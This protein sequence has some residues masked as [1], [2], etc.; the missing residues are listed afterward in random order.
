MRI[1]AVEE[2][3]SVPG[4][5]PELFGPGIGLPEVWAREWR[6]RLGDIGELR[7]ADMDAH[8]VDVQVLSLTAGVER[9]TNPAE[10]VDAARRANDHLA[11]AVAAHPDRFAGFCV[12][13]LQDPAAA[14]GELRRCVLELGMVGALQNDHV[15]GR[16]LDDIRFDEVWAELAQ[17]AVPL[18]LHPTYF[19]AERLALYADV[20]A[21]F[22]PTWGWTAATGGHALRLVYNGVFDRHPGAQLLLGHMGE[23]LPFQSA[24]LDSRAEQVPDQLRPPMAPSEYLRRNVH[25][26]TS[27]VASPAALRAAIDL[28]GV[29]RVLFAVDYPYERTAEAVELLAAPGISDAERAAVAHGNADRLLRLRPAG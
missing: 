3:F 4:V 10:A 13:P 14:V 23:L 29:D 20:P 28:V 18:Y 26:T 27:G 2:A 16:Y 9:L 12:L 7:L 15:G 24:R 17:L 22:G 6:T 25:I 8:G 19:A 21:L 11:A 5:T 1:V